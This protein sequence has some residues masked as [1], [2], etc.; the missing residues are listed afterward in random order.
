M[1]EMAQSLQVGYRRNRRTRREL[2]GRTF[3][4]F[5]EPIIAE[6]NGKVRFEDIVLGTTLKARDQ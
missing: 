2:N 6:K 1:C 3:D 5:T 4:P